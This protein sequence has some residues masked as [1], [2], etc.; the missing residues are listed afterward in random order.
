MR[1]KTIPERRGE[2]INILF[3]MFYNRQGNIG[4]LKEMDWNYAGGFMTGLAQIGKRISPR[5]IHF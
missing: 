1:R 2:L 3:L 4:K 5:K